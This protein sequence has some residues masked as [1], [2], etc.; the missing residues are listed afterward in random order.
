MGKWR[1]TDVTGAAPT[2]SIAVDHDT[3][4]MTLPET[5]TVCTAHFDGRDY[6]VKMGGAAS[7]QTWMFE[8]LG[9]LS[10]KVTTKLDGMPVG[11]DLMTLAADGKTMTDDG[12][13]VSVNEPTRGVYERK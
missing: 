7:K 2:L 5:Q 1:S 11:T 8:R 4:V 3:I 13:A 10:F 12:N 9:P 6:P